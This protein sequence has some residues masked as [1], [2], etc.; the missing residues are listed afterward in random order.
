LLDTVG[1]QVDPLLDPPETYPDVVPDLTHVFP[2]RPILGFD[3][4]TGTFVFGPPVLRFDTWSQNLGT[5]ALDLISDDPAN[6]ENPTVSQCVAWTGDVCRERRQVGG[7]ELHAAHNHFHFNEFARYELR[8]LLPDGTP[9][10]S[11][12]GLLDISEKVSFCLIDS[13]QVRPDARP[14]PVYVGCT[15]TR[16]GI[17]AGWADIYGASLAGQELS[18]AGGL[19]D[20]RYA[21]VISMDYGDRLYESDNGNNVVEATV[22]VSNG[23]TQAVIVDRRWP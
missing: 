5:V 17:S 10:Y 21:L 19:V 4:P 14:V 12:A 9:D 11:A 18:P 1:T 23:A 8:A 7:F 22:E 16:E 20:G 15:P 6:V 13:T 2:N 3:Q